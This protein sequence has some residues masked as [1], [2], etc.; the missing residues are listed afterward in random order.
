VRKHLYSLHEK[1]QPIV[2]QVLRSQAQS[3]GTHRWYRRD[4]HCATSNANRPPWAVAARNI[5]TPRLLFFYVCIRHRPADLRAATSA[6]KVLST[7]LVKIRLLEGLAEHEELGLVVDGQD[8]GTGNTT[9]DVGSGTLEERL[10]TLLGDDLATSVDGRL[11]LDGL[12][13]KD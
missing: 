8:T 3:K 9:E 12:E 5:A 1:V 4:A 11:V 7:H 2:I 10:D 13:W 6:A